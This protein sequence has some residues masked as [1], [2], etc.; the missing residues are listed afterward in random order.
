MVAVLA[1]IDYFYT[2]NTP[3]STTYD[4]VKREKILSGSRY[5]GPLAA[6]TFPSRANLAGV[7]LIHSYNGIPISKM[8]FVLSFEG[9]LPR[10]LYGLGSGAMR[11]ALAPLLTQ[12]RC[13]G[14][15]PISRFALQLFERHARELKN[16]AQITARCRVMYPSVPVVRESGKQLN[17]QCLTLTFV[18]SEWARKGGPAVVRLA[19]LLRQ[20]KISFKLHVVST[21]KYGID[22]YSDTDAA[23]YEPFKAML[24]GD[25]IEFAA[26]L[27]NDKV[28]ALIADSDF[29]L[30][31]TLDDSFGFSIL[32][33]M[34]L[35]V[36]VIATNVCAIPEIIQD[37]HD[38]VLIDCP[39]A[40][41]GRWAH[42]TYDAEV[43]ASNAYKDVLT[44]TIERTARAMHDAIGGLL[45]SPNRYE[46]LS[47]QAVKTVETRFNAAV[48]DREWHDVY[49][50]ALGRQSGVGQS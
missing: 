9:E 44:Q 49:M 33:S 4:V 41:N 8:P 29:C 24:A 17:R 14:L 11:R 1:G 38:G 31:P 16:A 43:R 48:R 5:W 7:D 46:A 12:D 37:G 3:R 20:S 30:L 18:G 10:S 22:Y 13:R 40:P 27:P 47:H 26:G 32:E 25:D 23:F 2:F 36:P 34:S 42:L 6:V 28:L 39:K 45:D 50:R 35:G 21:L 19:Q 15:F